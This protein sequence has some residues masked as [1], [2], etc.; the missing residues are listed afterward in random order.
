MLCF[1]LVRDMGGQVGEGRKRFGG[2]G[3][4]G[5][6]QEGG[7]YFVIYQMGSIFIN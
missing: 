7:S 2:G 5:Y 6:N 1:V 3:G 4:G